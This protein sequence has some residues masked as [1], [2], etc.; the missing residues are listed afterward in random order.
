MIYQ[1]S[2]FHANTEA[3]SNLHWIEHNVIYKKARLLMGKC[4]LKGYNHEASLYDRLNA[5]S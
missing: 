1:S 4:L 5:F 2:R 3:V